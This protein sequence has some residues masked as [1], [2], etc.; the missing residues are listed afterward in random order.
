MASLLLIITPVIEHRKVIA[1]SEDQLK[2]GIV[3]NALPCSDYNGQ[4]YVGSAVDLWRAIAESTLIG[5]ELQTIKNPNEAVR[6]AEN[7]TIDLGISCLNIV[8]PR[9][10]RVQFSIPY[11]SDSLGFLSKK[12]DGVRLITIFNKILSSKII[13][14]TL[15]LLYGVTLCASIILWL[16]SNGFKDKD[17]QCVNTYQ[18]FLKGWMMLAMGGGIYKLADNAQHMTII[19]LVNISRLVMSSILVGT[20]ASIIF[21]QKIPEDGSSNLFLKKTI[22]EGVGV[23][24]GTISELWIREQAAKQFKEPYKYIISLS[25][26]QQILGSLKSGKV[27]SILADYQRIKVLAKMLNRDSRFHVAASTFNKTPQAFIF[28][29]DLGYIRRKQININIASFMFNGQVD[30]IIKRWQ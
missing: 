19:T 20:I 10:K 26:D 25:G 9:L 28:G 14:T 8:S 1:G 21:Y 23:D 4:E 15:L 13:I 3:D 2:V 12:E 24:K 7:G 16:I 30:A 22:Q 17:I 18:T 11:Q 6:Q 5:Y 29:R 27:N